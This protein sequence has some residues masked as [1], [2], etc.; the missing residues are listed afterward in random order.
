M[1]KL[2]RANWLFLFLTLFFFFPC[3]V[4]AGADYPVLIEIQIAGEKSS[5]D[6][7]KIYNPTDSD[8][9]LG[10]YQDSYFRLVKRAKTSKDDYTIKSWSR[11][12]T[13]KIPAK[14]FYIW[15]NKNYLTLPEVDVSNSFSISPNNGVALRLGP[16]NAGEIIDAVGWGSFNNVLLERR[17][18][19]DNPAAQ[20]KLERKQ[21]QGIYQDTDDNSQDFY[22]NPPAKENPPEPVIV[23][24]EKPLPNQWSG[25]PA[26]VP[27]EDSPEKSPP[28]VY[29]SG[30][31]IN[32]I[33]PSPDGPDSQEEI[34][35]LFNQNDFEVNLSGWK[36]RDKVGKINTHVFSSDEKILEQGFIVLSAPLTKISLNNDN[37]GAELL[38][39]N[40][41]AVDTVNYTD[42]PRGSSY[43][44]TSSGWTWS[45][46]LT[47]GKEN[48]I[49][50]KKNLGAKKGDVNS[51]PEE[52]E[53][54]N[55][56]LGENLMASGRQN[57]PRSFFPILTAL[58]LSIFSGTIVLV[59]KQKVKD[60][61]L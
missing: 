51:T 30:V 46:V 50:Q 24:E 28:P 23:S 57:A 44:K 11:N 42:A 3:F 59:L 40:D 39:P 47:P 18:F 1:K 32:E 31:V 8:I 15:A 34:I 14:G 17:A 61:K 38:W 37:D 29:P 27:S 6:F 13:A 25:T 58:I 21:T 41:Q 16:E 53:K 33:L 10:E 36:I 55:F 4:S 60:K 9:Y 2:S 35:E 7:I 54:E 52:G 45:S 20:Q 5:D 22:L 19:S 48:V 56:S 26:D 12:P 43:N 49:D